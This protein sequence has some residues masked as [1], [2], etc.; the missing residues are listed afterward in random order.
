MRFLEARQNFFEPR[1][2]S[3]DLTEDLSVVAFSFYRLN[4]LA[5]VLLSKEVPDGFK[6]P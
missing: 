2:A 3:A 5:E 4:M 1:R 6:G